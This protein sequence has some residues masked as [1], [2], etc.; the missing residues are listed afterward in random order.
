MQ[1]TKIDRKDLAKTL[2]VNGSFTQEEIATKVG[3]TRQ[4]VSRWI[5]EGSW[6]QVKASYTITP[7]Q[8]LAG[9]NRQII[10]INN[11]VNSRPEGERFATVAEADTLAKLASSIKKIETDAGI[12]DIVNV[13]I[14]FT[15]W[16]R[17]TDLD[18]AKRFSDLLDA[19][20]KDQL[21]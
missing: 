7:E 14:K 8:I 5:R 3:T 16:L 2:Y 1:K 9:L 18:L 19:F 13:G 21:K 6:D 17:Q 20:I 10:E 12:A 15:N 11:N 4:T